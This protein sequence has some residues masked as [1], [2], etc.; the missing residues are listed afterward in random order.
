MQW[1]CGGLQIDT[2]VLSHLPFKQK[3]ARHLWFRVR[4]ALA[5]DSQPFHRIRN[6]TVVA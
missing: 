6:R 4:M 3:A 2:T 5:K 1:Y